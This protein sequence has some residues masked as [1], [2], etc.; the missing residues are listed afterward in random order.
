MDDR[1]MTEHIARRIRVLRAS[2]PM[3]GIGRTFVTRVVKKLRYE[4]TIATP[5]C[6]FTVKDEDL[7]WRTACACTTPIEFDFDTVLHGI[8]PSG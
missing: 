8:Y 2:R 1:T 5:R 6:V 3:L 4:G 7:L